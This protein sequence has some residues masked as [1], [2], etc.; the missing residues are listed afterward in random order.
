MYD[1]LKCWINCADFGRDTVESILK[2][3]H[4][5]KY[6]TKTNIRNLLVRYRYSSCSISIEG[7][8]TKFYFGNNI[9]TINRIQFKEVVSILSN[10]LMCDISK[11]KVTQLEFGANFILKNKVSEYIPLF[12]SCHKADRIIQ[13]M[14]GS[15]IRTLL[16]QSRAKL[17]TFRHIIYDKGAE[18]GLDDN[19]LRIELRYMREICKLL[20]VSRANKMTLKLLYDQN[21]YNSMVKRYY[22]FFNSIK[23]KNII[24]ISTKISTLSPKDAKGL[25]LAILMNDNPDRVEEFLVM[26]KANGLIPNKQDR[27]RFKKSLVS[28][29]EIICIEE[30]EHI[31]ELI[32]KV[33]DVCF[34]S[35][36]Y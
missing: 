7:S 21:F 19:I 2:H 1:R 30:S 22:N 5:T 14:R 12:G 10:E 29:C 32:N 8:F 33:K 24:N 4:L 36:S 35:K 3:L 27:L 6:N 34:S 31:I 16:Y 18:C 28:V 25:L 13:A 23:M 26:I 15:E 17:P 9:Q 11:A 20:N